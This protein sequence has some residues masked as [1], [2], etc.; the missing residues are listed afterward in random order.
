MRLFFMRHGQ[1][2]HNLHYVLNESNQKISRLTKQGEEEVR[3]SAQELKE[4]ADLHLI[5]CSPLKRCRQTAKMVKEE[6]RNPKLKIK[7]DTCLSEFKTGFNNRFAFIWFIRLLFTKNKLAKKFNDGQSIAE[8]AQEIE[9][10]WEKI[11][12]EHLDENILIVAHLHTY[13]M[14][15]HHLYNKQL[16]VPWR[17]KVYIA[18]GDFHEFKPKIRK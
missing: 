2:Q 7:I 1:A 17:Q 3:E 15:C 10:F 14:L 12:A 8:A 18:T 9:N 16:K 6:Q 11:H 4:E 13:Q 5:Y